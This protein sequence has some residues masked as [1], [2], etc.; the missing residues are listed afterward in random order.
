MKN[1]AR[2]FP[3]LLLATLALRAPA[4]DSP[5]PAEP[6]VAPASA[7]TAP[8][9]PR[10]PHPMAALMA[11][12]DAWIIPE[13]YV[14]VVNEGGAADPA[15]LD[16]FIPEISK[17]C[18]LRMEVVALDDQPDASAAALLARARAVAGDGARAFLVL[19]DDL[20]EPIVAGPGAGW[21]VMSP[22]WVRSDTTADAD[23]IADRMSKQ[24]Y[25]ALGF[26]FG[27]GIRL[28]PE[29]VVR[30]APT[31]SALDKAL[32][33]NFHPQ[34]LS[35]VQA[36]ARSL[37]LE[38]RHLKPRKELEAMGLLPPRGPKPDSQPTP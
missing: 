37:G 38:A 21:A 30:A 6:V 7:E 20:G 4:Q 16:T 24:F 14:A 35:V 12:P 22:A 8:K 26:A 17:Y 9:R 23:T 28:E 34:N 15:W 19:A 33:H 10:R 3:S 31:P 1:Y 36:V 18:Q 27:A 11:N 13:H 32:S 25:R 5:A 29:A 2:L